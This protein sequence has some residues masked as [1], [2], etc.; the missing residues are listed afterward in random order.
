MDP[1]GKA[2]HAYYFSNDTAVLKVN[3]NYT[4]DEELDP[5]WFFRN[6]EQMPE[7]EQQ[8]LKLCKGKILDVGAGAGAHT[9]SLQADGFEVVAL[10]QSPAAAEVMQHRGVK[11]L[12]VGNI[13]DY[14]GD[15]YDT[16]LLLM[17]GA[18][19]AGTLNGLDHLLAHLQGLLSSKGSI[20]ID[21]TDISY[22][23]EE[24][25]GSA[26]ID[27]TRENYFGEMEY[28]VTH[29]SGESAQFKWLYVDF[30]TLAKIAS[31]RGF[32]CRVV[33]EGSNDNYL[34]I[35]EPKS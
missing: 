9:L 20:L 15:T 5:A 24:E 31:S 28:E 27:L 14:Q 17:N 11:N 4:E 30:Q 34:A 18:G 26:W 23:F 25:D 10:D 16:I 35:L 33:A 19:I 8:A 1:I 13:F 3:S 22:L 12:V 6:R 2:I 21:S 32:A 7:L 29:H